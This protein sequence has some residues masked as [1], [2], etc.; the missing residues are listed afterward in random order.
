MI[1][2]TE[3]SENPIDFLKRVEAL[4]R[5]APRSS[6]VNGSVIILP[7]DTATSVSE[8]LRNLLDMLRAESF[9]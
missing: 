3:H 9:T 8:S 2:S 6:T 1:D 7:D 5:T 4:L